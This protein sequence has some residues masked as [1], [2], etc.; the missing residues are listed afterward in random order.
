MKMSFVD[1]GNN[2]SVGE[3]A[4]VLYDSKME[5]SSSLEPL[6]VL[7]NS[8]TLPEGTVFVGAPAKMV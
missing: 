4:V 1:I 3:M 5:D 6:S 7:M 2:C 8:E